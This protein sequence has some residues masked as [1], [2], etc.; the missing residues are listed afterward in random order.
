LNHFNLFRAGYLAQA[1]SMI[2]TLLR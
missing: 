1:M 2:D